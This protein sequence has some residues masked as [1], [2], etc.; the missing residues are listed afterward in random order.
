MLSTK[1]EIRNPKRVGFTVIE[2]VVAL[3]G[4]AVVVVAAVGYLMVVL[5]QRDQ[6]VAEAMLNQQPGVVFA[7]LGKV[8]RSAQQVTISNGSRR[9]EA[10][11]PDECWGFEWDEEVETIVY[12]VDKSVGC[13][14]PELMLKLTAST[15]KV[16]AASFEII[17]QSD[18]D[19]SIKVN[20]DVRVNRPFWQTEQHFEQVFVNVVDEEE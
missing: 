16:T 13:S 17:T 18:S 15:V 11:S 12:G 14:V 7:T 5:T 19:R 2:L 3:A 8:M 9:L 6:A 20:M 4:V 1:H 10:V